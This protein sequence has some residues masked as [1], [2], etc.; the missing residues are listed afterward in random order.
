MMPVGYQEIN[1]RQVVKEIADK[2]RLLMSGRIHH[3]DDGEP[4]LHIHNF[5]RRAYRRK[6]NVAD[7]PD[8]PAD[9]KFLSDGEREHQNVS[10]RVYSVHFQ[11][12]GEDYHGNQ[13]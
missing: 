4:D 3:V 8:K 13:H 6:R 5:A 7:K 9:K 11:D 2:T 10:G 1:Y 12:D